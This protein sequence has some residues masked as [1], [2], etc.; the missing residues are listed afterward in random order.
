MSDV[1][2]VVGMSAI[3]QHDDSSFHNEIKMKYDNLEEDV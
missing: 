3:S 2:N 1:R